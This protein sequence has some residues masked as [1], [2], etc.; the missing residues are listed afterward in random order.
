MTTR[1]LVLAAA[2]ATAL[3]FASGWG[4]LAGG[5]PYGV[6][7]LAAHKLGA[8]AALGAGALA[9]RRAA[10]RRPLSPLEWALAAMTLALTLA[11]FVGGIELSLHD[12]PP[13]WARPLHVAAQWLVVAGGVAVGVVAAS[14]RG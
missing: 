7:L 11:A 9:L 6:A 3:V 8:L 10:R 5:A 2:L 4:L 14:R 12:P 1:G 13:A